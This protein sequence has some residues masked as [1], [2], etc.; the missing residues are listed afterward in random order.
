MDVTTSGRLTLASPSRWFMRARL[1]VLLYLLLAVIAVIMLL[2]QR[3]QSLRSLEISELLSGLLIPVLVPAMAVGTTGRFWYEYL[4]NA[5]LG[6]LLPAIIPLAIGISILRYRLWDIDVIIRKTLVYSVLTGLLLMLWFGMVILL[7][8]LIGS[9]VGEQS[10]VVIVISTLVIAALAGALHR[11]VQNFIDRRFFR[12][13]YIAQQV[14]EQFART[15][16]DQV[17]LEALT[18]EVTR[19]VQETMQPESAFLWLR[20]EGPK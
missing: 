1:L 5:L 18:A 17:S 3:Y 19:V 14:L 2:P 11:R 20:G 15:A 12:R 10:P 6:V 8:T 4:T 16:R 9:F 13:K 7:Q